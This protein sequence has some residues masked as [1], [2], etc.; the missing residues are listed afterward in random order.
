MPRATWSS[1][2]LVE[3]IQTRSILKGKRICVSFMRKSSKMSSLM[4]WSSRGSISAMFS[5]YLF[6]CFMNM[7]RMIGLITMISS[8]FGSNFW[9]PQ[10]VLFF[11]WFLNLKS[12]FAVEVKLDLLVFFDCGSGSSGECGDRNCLAVGSKK[13][14]SFFDFCGSFVSLLKGLSILLISR[15]VAESSSGLVT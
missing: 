13:I 10:P 11:C 8:V 4:S 15:T 9:F 7:L 2:R 3:A 6:S 14:S 12:A 5:Q 1:F